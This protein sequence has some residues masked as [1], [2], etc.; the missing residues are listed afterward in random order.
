MGAMLGTI[1]GSV[2]GF[3]MSVLPEVFAMISSWLQHKRDMA[4]AQQRIDA[5]AKL[6]AD[7]PIVVQMTE[8]AATAAAPAPIVVPT[9]VPVDEDVPQTGWAISLMRFLRAS[10][11]PVVTYGFFGI[12]A[13]IKL[14]SMYHAL[15]IDGTPA[16][17]LLPVVWNEGTESLFAAVLAFWFGSRAIE[18]LK[19]GSAS[20]ATQK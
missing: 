10:V 18:K 7:S 8:A 6:G 1:L 2:L 12:F 15:V 14:M 13:F 19:T 4:N 3:V 20:N 5:S 16:I 11:R 9:T 17:Q